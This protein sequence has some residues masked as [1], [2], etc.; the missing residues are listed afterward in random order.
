MLRNLSYPVTFQNKRGDQLV[1]FLLSLK[2]KMMTAIKTLLA[3]AILVILTM[4]LLGV[5]EDATQYYHRW[6]NRT[7]PHGTPLKVFQEVEGPLD[8]RD[9]PMIKKVLQDYKP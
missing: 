6:L 8:D 2:K 5:I 9:D 4:Q 3:V 1:L 7:N